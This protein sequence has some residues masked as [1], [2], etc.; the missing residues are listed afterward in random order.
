MTTAHEVGITVL[1]LASRSVSSLSCEL[2]S[3]EAL[4]R[5]TTCVRSSGR[6]IRT[7]LL[8]LLELSAIVLCL[9]L[10]STLGPTIHT[11]LVYWRRESSSSLLFLDDFEGSDSSLLIGLCDIN[12]NL[13]SLMIRFCS[14]LDFSL[15]FVSQLRSEIFASLFKLLFSLNH[16]GTHLVRECR[17]STNKVY[18]SGEFLSVA[19]DNSFLD[20]F[21]IRLAV[22]SAIILH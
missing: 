1:C 14:L 13:D 3:V 22:L 7:L 9:L 15:K 6:P 12:L 10:A 2:A 17:L 16:H 11:V 4:I 19:V 5:L 20:L 18:L 8:F 21:D